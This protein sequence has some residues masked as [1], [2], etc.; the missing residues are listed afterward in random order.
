MNAS[1]AATL[2][3]RAPRVGELVQVR[4]RRWL[5]DEVVESVVPGESPRVHLTCA[6]DD[7]PG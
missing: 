1:L 3:Q 4:P 6:D 2:P 7:A 5:V